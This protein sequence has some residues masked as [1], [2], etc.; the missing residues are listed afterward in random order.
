MKLFRRYPVLAVCF[1]YAALTVA[2][3]FPLLPKLTTAIPQGGGDTYQAIASIRTIASTLPGASLAA[4]GRALLKSLG[5]FTPYALLSLLSGP[6]VAYNLLFLASYFLSALG[7]YLLARHFTRNHAASLL[8]GL[9]FAFS[10]FHFYQS[11]AVHVGTMHQEWLPFFALLL[12]RFFERFRFRFFLGA[13]L[14]AFL[15]ALAEHQLLAFTVLFVL[16]FL[17]YQTIVAPDFLR[18]RTFWAYALVSGGLLAVLVFGL[19]GNYLTVALSAD[20]FLNAGENAA[21]RYSMPAL[22]PLLPP[23]FHGLWPQFGSALE[24]LALGGTQRGSYFVGYAALLLVLWFLFRRF[25]P[26]QP[27]PSAV[28]RRDI[29]FWLAVTGIFFLFSL[30][31]SVTLFGLNIPLPYALVYKFLPFYENIRTTGRYFVYAMLGFSMLLAYAFAAFESRFA[32]RK[33]L[34]ASAFA[35]VILLEFWVA[36][37]PTMSLDYSAFYDRLARDPA[38]YRLLEIPGSTSYEFASYALYLQSIH[39]KPLLGGVTFA[40]RIAGQFDLEQGTPIVK[41]LLYTLPKG[42]DPDTKDDA[43]ILRP[44]DPSGATAVLN[45]VHVRYIILHKRYLDTDTLALTEG[46]IEKHIAFTERFEDTSLLAYHVKEEVPSGFYASLVSD[47]REYSDKFTDP[48]T[49]LTEREIGDGGRLHIVNMAPTPVTVRI[50]LTATAPAPLS[51]GLTG[52]SAVLGIP[53]PLATTA[54]TAFFEAT[55]ASG[56]NDLIIGVTDPS[57]QAVRRPDQKKNAG[58]GAFVSAISITVK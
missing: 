40:R 24:T 48:A 52:R 58:L 3:T 31:V 53:A 46:Y 32:H 6:L 14:F 35:L 34:F 44:F 37:L 11:T 13:A 30:G 28:S 8:A 39:H 57:G 21:N 45:Y 4:D 17:G 18:Q 2:F 36:P 9:I 20:N 51:I 23:S 5:T 7:A 29:W 10:P 15:I 43:D 12:F 50:G 33:P 55:L 42:N 22:A 27:L 16:V 47:H 25:F 56:A 1:L 41:E 54:R 19:F 49:G 26:R 38:S